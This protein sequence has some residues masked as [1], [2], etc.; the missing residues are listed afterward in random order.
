[1]HFISHYKLYTSIL[2]TVHICYSNTLKQKLRV[3]VLKQIFL[4]RDLNTIPPSI[5]AG[6]M[7]WCTSIQHSL[8]VLQFKTQSEQWLLCITTSYY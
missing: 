6:L 7:G 2:T 4:T 5:L 1:M 3:C 8:F